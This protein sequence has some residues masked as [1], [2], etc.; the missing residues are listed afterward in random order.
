MKALPIKCARKVHEDTEPDT[1]ESPPAL[2]HE[3]LIAYKLRTNNTRIIRSKVDQ[4]H[5]T[6]IVYQVRIESK[7]VVTILD[8]SAVSNR[9]SF[10]SRGLGPNEKFCVKV[11]VR[12]S[13]IVDYPMILSRD[14]SM[15]TAMT[16]RPTLMENSPET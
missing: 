12:N 6:P 15:C 11:V 10:V 8:R 13:V 9:D 16:V 5:V 2:T 3:Q 14:C 4:F 7:I 1:G